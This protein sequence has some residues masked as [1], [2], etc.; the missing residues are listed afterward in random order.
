MLKTFTGLILAAALLNTAHAQSVQIREGLLTDAAGRV[1]YVFDKDSEGKS[2]CNGQCAALWPPFPAA[3]D[4]AAS[5]EY[6]TVR[7]DDGGLQ[8]AHRGR[9]LYYYAS[10]TGPG[11]ATGEGRGGVWHVVRPATAAPEAGGNI[12]PKGY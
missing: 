6:T 4:A 8:W 9:P 7:R 5:S 3:S 2:A 12:A 1:L 11:Q 10:D